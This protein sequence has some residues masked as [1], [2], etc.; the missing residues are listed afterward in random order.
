MSERR[1]RSKTFD[2]FEHRKVGAVTNGIR[3]PGSSLEIPDGVEEL[4]LNLRRPR[5][6]KI[7]GR[8]RDGEVEHWWL[9]VTSKG[10]LTLV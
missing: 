7:I 8:R 6:I 5:G 2:G 1:D 10:K 4:Q 9:K 3:Q